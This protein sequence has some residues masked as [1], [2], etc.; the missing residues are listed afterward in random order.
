MASVEAAQ[1]LVAKARQYE[2]VLEQ[3]ADNPDAADEKP[4]HG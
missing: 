4:G 2:Y 3:F 1:L